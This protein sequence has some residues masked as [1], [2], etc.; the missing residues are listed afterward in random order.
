VL[1]DFKARVGKEDIFKPTIGNESLH[2]ISDDTG[3]R[4]VNF[5]TFKN[6]AVKSTNFP[7]RNVHKYTWTSPDRKTH[8]K[9]DHILVDRLRHSSVLDVRS[10]RT[11]DCESD[12]CLEVAKVRKLNEQRSQK[13]HMERFNLIEVKRGRG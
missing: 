8:N 12:H 1:G 6:L 4:L 2:E 7:R 3:V 13:F 9:I 5:D 11:A 10:F